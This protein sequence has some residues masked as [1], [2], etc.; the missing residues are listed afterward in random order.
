MFRLYFLSCP[1]QQ[2][3]EMTTTKVDFQIVPLYNCTKCIRKA[4]K[5]LC[6]FDGVE[7]LDVDSENGKFTIKT[8]KNPEEIRAALQRK[9]ARK[10]VFLSNIINH[11]NPSSALMNPRNSSIQGPLNYH[12]M[13]ALVAVARANGA[14]SVEFRQSSTIIF[15]FKNQPTTS[16]TAMNAWDSKDGG[17]GD[18]NDAPPPPPPPR[19]Y[20]PTTSDYGYA[21]PPPPRTT[22]GKPLIPMAQAQGYVYGYPI[23]Y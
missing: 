7:L 5:T 13:E 2:I 15:N 17:Y 9:F 19:Q 10:S 23:D 14:Q 6:G 21:P 22:S 18:V 16:G 4:E 8:T 12:D 20:Q 1:I 11:S 3:S